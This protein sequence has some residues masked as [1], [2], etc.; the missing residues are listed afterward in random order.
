M[1]KHILFPLADLEAGAIR[2]VEVDGHQI[3]VTRVGEDVYG[4]GDLCTHAKVS[5][6]SEGCVDVDDRTIE[7][8]RHGA[9]FDLGSGEAKTLPATRPL[10]TYKVSVSDDMVV[11]AI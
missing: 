3:A 5:L 7:C 8:E 2:Q 10:P 1:A 9:V 6:S 11:L 4:V